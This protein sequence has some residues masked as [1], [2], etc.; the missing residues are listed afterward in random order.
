MV[1]L[2]QT[3]KD[4]CRVCESV[5]FAPVFTCLSV[6]VCTI[7]P[8]LQKTWGDRACCQTVER[9]NNAG[10]KARFNKKQ[11]GLEMCLFRLQ[12]PVGD[13]RM[14]SRH[15]ELCPVNPSLTGKVLPSP[16]CF[17]PP[18][19]RPS[20]IAHRKGISSPVSLSLKVALAQRKTPLFTCHSLKSDFH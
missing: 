1:L 19:P 15:G 18:R 8:F 5:W 16:G 9:Q 10:R 12:P 14:A 20:F 2:A 3:D 7:P 11:A 17:P 13:F 6:F 4:S